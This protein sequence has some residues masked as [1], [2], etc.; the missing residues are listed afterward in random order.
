MVFEARFNSTVLADILAIPTCKTL[1]RRHLSTLFIDLIGPQMYQLKRDAESQSGYQPLSASSKIKHTKRTIN[2]SGIFSHK[3]TKSQDSRDFLSGSIF[4]RGH[5]V[6][7][8]T[9]EHTTKSLLNTSKSP[10]SPESNG[11]I[12]STSMI[13]HSSTLPS[14]STNGSFAEAKSIHSPS[15]IY[16]NTSY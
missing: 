6:D 10:K 9:F 13:G 2:V 14:N 8:T 16:I 1:L 5:S 11:K 12:M 4:M 15:V 3:R 7:P